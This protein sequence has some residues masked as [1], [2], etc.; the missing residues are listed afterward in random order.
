MSAIVDVE[1]S[2]TTPTGERWRVFHDGELLLKSCREPLFDG[3]RALVAKGVTGR[4]QTRRNG[5]ICME[6][7]IAVCATL[8]VTEGQTHGPRIV[9][10]SSH[11]MAKE[12]AE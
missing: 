8:T 1:F 9:K 11:F 10:W 12:A 4:I 6:G 3:A 2:H 5:M 7:L